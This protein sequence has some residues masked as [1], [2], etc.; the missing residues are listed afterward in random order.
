MGAHCFRADEPEMTPDSGREVQVG[1]EH[2]Q[3]QL[4][5]KESELA[6][7][8]D[9]HSR[10]AAELKALKEAN[11]RRET[12]IQEEEQTKLKLQKDVEE[13]ERL[14]EEMKMQEQRINAMEEEQ[15]A[16]EVQIEEKRGKLAATGGKATT[17]K[18]GE[19]E[20][21]E[22]ELQESLAQLMELNGAL[23]Q[24]REQ[25]RKAERELAETESAGESLESEVSEVTERMEKLRRNRM[26]FF[27]QASLRNIFLYFTLCM[28]N[29]TLRRFTVWKINTAALRP[30]P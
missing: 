4:N 5:Y 13:H 18:N 19:R 27:R 15:T 23:T 24:E 17:S 3:A 1:I 7:V 28:Q 16:L 29:Q 10:L 20:R 11:E 26:L 25:K 6:K 8:S 9:E 22:K 12:E 21:L 2:Y 30:S 14:L